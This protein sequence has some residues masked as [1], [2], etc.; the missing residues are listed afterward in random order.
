MVIRGGKNIKKNTKKINKTKTTYQN[1]VKGKDRM[2]ALK[3]GW[4]LEM[5]KL[6]RI[7]TSS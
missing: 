1:S 5:S 4:S 7:K 2:L 3:E 6:S